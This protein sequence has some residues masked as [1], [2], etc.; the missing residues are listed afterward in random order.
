MRFGGARRF[1]GSA[2]A[3]AFEEGAS[4]AAAFETVASGAAG[5]T[6]GIGIGTPS[7]APPALNARTTAKL[8]AALVTRVI[9][10]RSRQ[11]DAF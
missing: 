8:K 10:R 2:L 7:P 1:G 6:A 4:E 5:A 9:Y 3:L 11:L